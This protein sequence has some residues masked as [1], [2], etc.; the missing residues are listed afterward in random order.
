MN[1]RDFLTLA[2]SL[3]AGST[4]AEWRSA[5]SRAYYAVFHIA[6]QLFTDLGFTVPQSD[7]AH[8][9]LWYRLSNTGDPQ[10]AWAGSSL[11]DL[12]SLR[13]EADYDLHRLASQTLAAS[14]VQLAHR[15]I[16]ALDSAGN[17]PTRTQITDAIKDYELN[18]L[19]QVTWRPPP[20]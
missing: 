2:D 6:R 13:N 19:H 20:P 18:V 3:V 1:G 4:E 14:H 8:A 15:I 5:V 9:Y 12:R 11:N 10:V 17:E 16:Q 7:R